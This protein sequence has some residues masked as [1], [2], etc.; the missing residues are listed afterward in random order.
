VQP[1]NRR[2][3]WGEPIKY[4]EYTAAGLPVIMSDLPAKRKLVESYRNGILVNP[5][6]YRETA[7]KIAQLLHDNGLRKKMSNKGIHAFETQLNW[8]NVEAKMIDSIRNLSE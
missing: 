6:D 8:Q 7:L 1:T 2:Y 4:F 3:N 5:K